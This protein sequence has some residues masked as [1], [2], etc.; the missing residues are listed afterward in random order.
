MKRLTSEELNFSPK[1]F[2]KTF[3]SINWTHTW[4]LFLIKF[5][6]GFSVIL[7]RSNF[8]LVM[9]ESFNT[10]PRTIGYLTSFTGCVSA[11]FGLIVGY[12]AK[13]YRNDTKLFFHMAVFQV[14]TLFVLSFIQS[15]WVYVLF[16]TPLSFI[17]TVSRVAG[18]SLTIRRVSKGEIG[19]IMG[20]SQSVM[21]IARMLA[22][23]VSGLVLDVNPAGPSVV[24][25]IVTLFAVILMCF[26]PQDVCKEEMQ[27]HGKTE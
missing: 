17:T 2:M 9:R 16:L 1:L 23:F 15:F 8:S 22:P 12:L 13:F 24:G 10:S 26:V 14:F 3:H 21:S 19:T 27:E 7:F 25:S 20:F 18:T 4:D 5:C 11:F 6:M